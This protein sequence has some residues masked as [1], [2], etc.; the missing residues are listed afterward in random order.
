MLKE[1]FARYAHD[2]GRI[3]DEEIAAWLAS[4][5]RAIDEGNFFFVLPQFVVSGV[6]P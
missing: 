3:S 4:V 6:K 2:S 1:S 5:Q